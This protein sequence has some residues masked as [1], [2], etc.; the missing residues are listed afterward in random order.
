MINKNILIRIRRHT[1]LKVVTGIYLFITFGC[2]TIEVEEPNFQLTSTTVFEEDETAEAAVLGIYSN[3]MSSEGF[4]S[5][6]FQSLTTVTGLAADDLVDYSFNPPQRQFFENALVPT[7]TILE[8]NLWNEAYRYIYHANAI[9]EG[10]E[11]SSSLTPEVAKRLDGETRF[12][13]A[14]CYFHLVNLFGEIPLTTDTDYEVN[15]SIEASPIEDAY[16][17]IRE[18][19]NAAIESLPEDYSFA[20]GERIR[21]NKWAA[22]AFLAR[23]ELYRQNYNSAE[24]HASQVIDQSLY[25]LPEDLNAVF[26][27]NSMEAIL[28]F[29]PI[30]RN[31]NTKEGRM[32]ILNFNPFHVSLRPGLVESF[33]AEDLRRSQW[34][35]S[36]TTDQ[37][38]YYPFKY[39][40]RFSPTLT[41]YS[42]V[43]RLAEQYLIRAEARAMQGDITGGLQDLNTIRSR[44]GLSPLEISDAGELLDAILLER[45]HELFTE[46]AHRWYDLK[47][48]ERATEVLEPLKEQWH[49]TDML[50]PIP[51]NEIRKNSNLEQNAGY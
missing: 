46:R 19:L 25:S 38:Y 35:G 3:M 15:S 42:M 47:R 6:S 18:D 17:L 51:Q 21:P 12:I 13:R 23:I 41:E 33:E 45:R 7:N 28:Q 30:L 29:R 44:A 32:F 16:Q 43:F 31:F 27:A 37:T 8:F 14:F 11:Q 26:L 50:F 34:V 22:Y 40:V 5:G 9:L 36:L 49:E 39:K 48:T 20:G 4:V 2:E 24:L 10:I 1:F